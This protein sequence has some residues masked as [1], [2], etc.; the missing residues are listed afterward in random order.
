MNENFCNYA[1]RALMQFSVLLIDTSINRKNIR[2]ISLS[3]RGMWVVYLSIHKVPTPFRTVPNNF[4]RNQN[5][6]LA[7]KI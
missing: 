1:L 5:F 3:N 6:I 7:V 4:K 2:F